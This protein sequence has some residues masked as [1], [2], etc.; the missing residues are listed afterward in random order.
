M[1]CVGNAVGLRV[2]Q[3]ERGDYEIGDR[4]VRELDSNS[5]QVNWQLRIDGPPYFE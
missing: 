1:V 3:C 2:F 5:D 4:L